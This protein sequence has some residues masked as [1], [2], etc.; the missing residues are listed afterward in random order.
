MTTDT[1][2]VS[3]R[4]AEHA[5]TAPRPPLSKLWF[6]ELRKL[7]D[8]LS[9]LVLLGTGVVLAGLFGGGCVLYRGEH[10]TFTEVAVM[11]GVPG[12]I[13]AT[14]MAILLVTAEQSQ[15][16]ALTTFALTPRRGRIIAAKAGAVAV[17]GLAVVLLAMA[18][19]VVILPV[20][21]MTTGHQAVWE[22]DG[23]RL[24]WF[25]VGTVA[26]AMSGFALGLAVGN[27]PVAIVVVLVWPMLTSL[28]RSVP[29]AADTLAW[30]DIAA[31]AQLDDGATAT[32]FAQFWSGIAVWVVLPMAI[33]VAR[34][35]RMEVR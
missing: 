2:R 23:A 1:I 27:A 34:V 29:G 5:L 32:E 4:T 31:A 14:V 12:G 17:L 22:V 10:A 26:G 16:T 18:A 8:T 9:G 11:A 20:G 33:G 7:A 3:A 24:F 28:L 13:L 25:T 15:R 6:V 35:L 30:L 19:A 21:G